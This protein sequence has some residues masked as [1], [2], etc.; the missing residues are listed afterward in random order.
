MNR[1]ERRAAQ[2]RGAGTLLPG[3]ASAP[4][5]A[6]PADRHF[7]QA[8][9]HFGVGR[10]AEAEHACRAA[11]KS[12]PRHF[13]ALHMLGLIAVRAGR[14]E[15]AAEVLGRA[16]T[17]N[18][19]NADCHFSRGRALA[20]MGRLDE[21]AAHLL[22]AVELN[23]ASANA[24]IG[25]GNIR[26]Q[27]G[28]LEGAAASY[29][30][31]LA[32]DP[33]NGDAHYN[34]GNVLASQG[35]TEQAISEYHATLASG[36]GSSDVFNSLATALEEQ[37][38][39]ES[40]LAI[41]RRALALD[42]KHPEL[43]NNLGNLYWRQ[44]D[45]EQAAASYRRSL[46]AR[47]HSATAQNNLGNVL[48]KQ[49]HAEDARE[50]FERGLA[51]APE[52]SETL[53][54]LCSAVY[55]IS[56]QD[57]DAAMGH[58]RRLLATCQHP[59]LQR[60]LAGLTGATVDE[61]Q[62]SAY[63]R[64]VFEDFAGSFDSTLAS[65]GYLDMPRAMAQAAAVGTGPSGLDI[66]DAGCG[67]GLCGSLFKPAA[68]RLTGVD[69][70]PRMLEKAQALSIYDEL[71]AADV[72][73]FM[74]GRA[75]AFDL[76]VSSDVLPYMGDLSRFLQAARASLRPQGRLV[77]SAESLDREGSAEGYRLFASGRYKHARAYL[78]GAFMSAGLTVA[79]VNPGVMRQEANADVAAWIVVGQRQ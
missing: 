9:H 38:K 69:I 7:A 58:A 67:T 65:L 26:K 1:K 31:A 15:E 17:V 43:L 50:C 66:L 68:R 5:G 29:R 8:V 70:S 64:A 4:F 75:E 46:A 51:I 73:A 22:R 30:Q 54:S 53:L 16:I 78:E 48:L 57:R 49:G 59:L 12:E 21:A 11:L 23:P 56:L 60:G 74:T 32:L 42:P 27:K 25:L 20:E 19:A 3:A 40:A 61:T 45:L 47:P 37:G 2:S 76:I 36:P 6:G 41:Y 33:S 44:G 71:V 18:D 35:R 24:M 52:R 14:N 72:I 39:I 28:D 79:T 63:A 10:L 77:I 55:A 13:N 34:L 62:D